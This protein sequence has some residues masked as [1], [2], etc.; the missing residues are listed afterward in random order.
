VACAPLSK[1]TRR[2][3]SYGMSDSGDPRG[4]ARPFRQTR[5]YDELAVSDCQSCTLE[6][7]DTT[8]ERALPKTVNRFSGEGFIVFSLTAE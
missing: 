6:E 5:H 7:S 1:H 4:A 3:I 2:D 8:V